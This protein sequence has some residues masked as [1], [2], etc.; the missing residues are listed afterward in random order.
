MAK[1]WEGEQRENQ[2]EHDMRERRER[3]ERRETS[4]ALRRQAR[5][6]EELARL[7]REVHGLVRQITAPQ[8]DRTPPWGVASG[9]PREIACLA[10]DVERIHTE[11]EEPQR[12]T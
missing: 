11:E 8:Q 4:E 1:R 12:W 7:A 10:Q 3:R 9:K 2:G 6:D 5:Q